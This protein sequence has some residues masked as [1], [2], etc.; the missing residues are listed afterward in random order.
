MLSPECRFSSHGNVMQGCRRPPCP[1]IV[2]PTRGSRSR[3]SCDQDQKLYCPE[4]GSERFTLAQPAAVA[5]LVFLIFRS[6]K[7]MIRADDHCPPCASFNPIAGNAFLQRGA[8][9]R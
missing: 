9:G 7:R 3:R 5:A 1:A 2:R 4:L 8:R 6:R